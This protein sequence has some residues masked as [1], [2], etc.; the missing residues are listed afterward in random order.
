MCQ[1]KQAKRE[2]LLGWFPAIEKWTSSSCWSS[3]PDKMEKN[4]GFLFLSLIFHCI[5]LFFKFVHS[6]VTLQSYII[7]VFVSR[8]LFL[9]LRVMYFPFLCLSEASADLTFFQRQIFYQF[10]IPSLGFLENFRHYISEFLLSKIVN[11]KGIFS[12]EN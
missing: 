4:S 10:Q 7:L 9:S 5:S 3:S 6:C 12:L 8:Y 2:K 1:F 11:W